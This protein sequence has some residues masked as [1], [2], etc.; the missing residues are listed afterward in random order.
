MKGG[1]YMIIFLHKF[2]NKRIISGILTVVLCG[3]CLY[4]VT[5]IW[6]KDNLKLYS[7]SYALTDGDSGRVL[8]GKNEHSAMAN[9][10]TT[11]IITCIIALENCDLNENVTISAY[12]ASQPKVRLGMGEGEQYPLKDMLYGLM[13]ESYN[14]C[15]V[16]IAEHV[17]GSVE[18]FA[19]M[20]NEKAV[21]LGCENTFFLTPNGLDQEK[22]NQFH[23]TTATDLCKIMAYCVWESPVKNMFL[24]ITQTKE[25]SGVA[26]NNSYTFINRNALLGQMDG[27]LSGKTGYTAKAGY[28]Y[29]AAYEKDGEKYCVALLA[30]GWPNN[31][32]WKWQDT[33]ALLNFARDN[34][35]IK[36]II[37]EEIEEQIVI[38][39]YIYP[40]QFALLNQKDIVEITA[41][42]HEYTVLLGEDEQVRKELLLYNNTTLPIEKGQIMGQCNIYIEDTILDTIM[43]VSEDA[44]DSWKLKDIIKVILSQ[45]FTFSS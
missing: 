28:C 11:K 5:D 3:L 10:S 31:K 32:T 42:E 1:I 30:C 21:E 44:S 20:M 15:A 40:P 16:A 45:F 8:S 17:A 27:L 19:D 39:G 23:H 34:F 38:D 37:V 7:S 9:A 25:Y 22:E 13:L 14:D 12:A 36:K 41:Q 26:N 6:A 29:V 43:L 33:R 2:R 24:E 4:D 35:D 18:E